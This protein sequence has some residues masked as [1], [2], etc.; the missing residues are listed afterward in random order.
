V[1]T[2]IKL[3]EQLSQEIPVLV[4]TSEVSAV[5]QQQR[6]LHCLLEAPVPLLDVAVLV[7]VACLDLLSQ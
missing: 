7:A 2:R 3:T 6:L 1:P 4:P 5:A